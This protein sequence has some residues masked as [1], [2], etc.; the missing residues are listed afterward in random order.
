MRR[1][2]AKTKTESISFLKIVMAKK[3]SD[4]VIQEY[5]VMCYKNK[6]MKEV[7][8]KSANKIKLN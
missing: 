2:K 8:K 1:A 3:V 6:D 5:S 4:N 7:D